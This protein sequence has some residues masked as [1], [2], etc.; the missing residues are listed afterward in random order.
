MPRIFTALSSSPD[1]Q[2]SEAGPDHHRIRDH[3]WKVPGMFTSAHSALHGK[4]AVQC[5]E[6]RAHIAHR[7]TSVTAFCGQNQQTLAY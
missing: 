4:V 3:N 1:R 5:V 6:P 2:Q 7:P